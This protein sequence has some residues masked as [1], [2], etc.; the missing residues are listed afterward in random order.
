MSAHIV[1]RE[2]WISSIFSGFRMTIDADDEQEAED[3]ARP[4]GMVADVTA[5]KPGR[6]T[7]LVIDT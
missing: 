5:V 4:H 6:F 7:V 2:D 1:A 3:F